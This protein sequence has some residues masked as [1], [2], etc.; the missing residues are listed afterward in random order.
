MIG[1]FWDVLIRYGDQI[2]TRKGIDSAEYKTY[3]TIADLL[4]EAYDQGERHKETVFDFQPKTEADAQMIKFTGLDIFI[5]PADG[6]YMYELD[7][8]HFD[9]AGEVIDALLADREL[10]YGRMRNAIIRKVRKW[11]DLKAESIYTGERCVALE[12]CIEVR[13]KSDENGKTKTEGDDQ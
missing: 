12:D 9:T 13:K 3:C 8:R 6:G 4:Q 5:D 1:A 11:F 10:H 2:K 7:G